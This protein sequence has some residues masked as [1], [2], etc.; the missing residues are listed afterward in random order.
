MGG[1][2]IT[3]VN[4]LLLIGAADPSCMGSPIIVVGGFSRPSLSS[5]PVH[6][7]W[8]IAGNDDGDF[9]FDFRFLELCGKL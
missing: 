4:G 5:C 2:L 6:E 7:F 8:V 3:G 1:S 9:A